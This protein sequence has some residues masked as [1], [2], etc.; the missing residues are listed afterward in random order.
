MATGSEIATGRGSRY[1]KRYT[2]D[3]VIA[4]VTDECEDSGDE[5]LGELLDPMSDVSDDDRDVDEE[6][7]N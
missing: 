5:E 4:R 3:D 6:Q 2:V 7:S 1:K